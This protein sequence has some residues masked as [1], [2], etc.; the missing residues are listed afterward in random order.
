MDILVGSKSLHYTHFLPAWFFHFWELCLEKT[1]LLILL[2]SVATFPSSVTEGAHVLVFFGEDSRSLVETHVPWWRLV[3]FCGH[4]CSFVETCVLLW[5][6]VF[7][8]GELCACFSKIQNKNNKTNFR[9]NICILALVYGNLTPFRFFGKSPGLIWSAS[10]LK[11]KIKI[12][13]ACCIRGRER[14]YGEY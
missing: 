12:C 7:F 10:F 13:P 2:F 3:F 4:L 9:P 1:G 14:T 6:F 8:C 11:G 5:R